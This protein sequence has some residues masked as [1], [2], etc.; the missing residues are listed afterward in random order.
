MKRMRILIGGIECEAELFEDKAPDTVAALW[1]QLPFVDRTYHVANSGQAW[2]TATQRPL[3]PSSHPV[4]NL[5]DRL[6]P[7][8]IIY[9]Y[10]GANQV[11][12][13]CY[14]KARWYDPGAKPLD[15]ALIGKIDRN[16]DDFVRVSSR[17]LYDG[18][19]TVWLSRADS[20]QR[21]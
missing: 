7:G 19:L 2:R 4:E 18:N 16:L 12:G 17:I 15:V 13:F 8:D 1:A 21:S 20:A 6:G 9:H 14:G 3:L 10:R 5:A 11:V